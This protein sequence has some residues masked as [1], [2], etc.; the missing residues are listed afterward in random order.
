MDA[1][2]N[3][4]AGRG[5]FVISAT[6]EELGAHDAPANLAATR[7][8]LR[9]LDEMELPFVPC[10]GIYR[11]VPQGRSFLVI[12]NGHV[13]R[14]LCR[15]FRQE[16]IL[17]ADGLVNGGGDLLAKRVGD[18]FGDEAEA[19]DFYSVFGGG[20]RWSADLEFPATADA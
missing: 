11:G 12:A 6:R 20:L 18:R 9:Y 13:G 16:S 19:S 15:A 7:D 8:L 10:D 14:Y 3:I 17:T 2:K 1:I 5:W 4:I